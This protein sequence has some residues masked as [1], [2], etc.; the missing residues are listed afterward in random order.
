ML[1]ENVALAFGAI[2]EPY[3]LFL[4]IVGVGAGLLAD[5]IPGYTIAM[6]I[7]LTLPED[8]GG[9]L[10]FGF[11]AH[12]DLRSLNHEMVTGVP[13]RNCGGRESPRCGERVGSH[14]KAGP[15]ERGRPR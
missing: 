5:A 13:D 14:E 11:G 10:D 4:M 15:L 7:V 12:I 3:T 8:N 1:L 9:G 2:F 6:A